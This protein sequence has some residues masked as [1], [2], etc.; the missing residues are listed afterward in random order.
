[1]SPIPSSS[2][3]TLWGS[4]PCPPTSFPSVRPSPS[5]SLS[6]GEVAW[7]YTSSPSSRPSL[8]V[9]WSEGSVP[10]TSVSWLSERP[11]PSESTGG[12][13]CRSGVDASGCRAVGASRE[14]PGTV[15]STCALSRLPQAAAERTRNHEAS[16]R[17]IRLLLRHRTVD[18]EAE[19]RVPPT[20][21]LRAAPCSGPRGLY[22]GSNP[23]SA[24]RSWALG[25]M[26]LFGWTPCDPRGDPV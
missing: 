25:P 6:R 22:P 7:R 5:V 13:G 4:V 12:G 10:W 2:E 8:S 16:E 18:G 19:G 3:S 15:G 20:S 26:Y 9:S 23:G 21:D 11:S 1:M 14:G 24:D 17:G